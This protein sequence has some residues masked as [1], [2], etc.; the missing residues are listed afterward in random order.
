MKSKSDS[1]AIPVIKESDENSNEN[2]FYFL[3]QTSSQKKLFNSLDKEN[4]IIFL[5]ILEISENSNLT[6]FAL[7]TNIDSK[8][9]PLCHIFTQFHHRSKA[10]KICLEF[11]NE[12]KFSFK[13]CLVN[14]TENEILNAVEISLNCESAKISEKCRKLFFSQYFYS[15]N[16]S[17]KLEQSLELLSECSTLSDLDRLKEEAKRHDLEHFWEENWITRLEKWT[18]ILAP[19][20]YLDSMDKNVVKVEKNE[21][22]S[23]LM[24]N[25]VKKVI[26]VKLP[27]SDVTDNE[28]DERIFRCLR[29]L[30]AGLKAKRGQEGNLV[31]N[32]ML[33]STFNNLLPL[34]SDETLM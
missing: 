21:I 6:I 27:I 14:S 33:E 16:S 34:L 29:S 2:F 32:Q 10:L 22:N 30:K 12:Q 20:K 17:S 24:V 13:N 28:S 4:C 5:D 26:D 18:A 19:I 31:F 7:L 3:H 23:C 25:I 9:H 15:K 11:V 8:F 1:K